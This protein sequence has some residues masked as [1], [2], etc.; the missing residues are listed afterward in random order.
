MRLI[1]AQVRKYRSIRDT[2][3][4]EIDLKKTILVGPNESG[5]TVLLQALQQLNPTAG[6]PGFEPL[7]DY[8]RSE[9]NDITTGAVKPEHVE[10]VTGWFRLETEDK[11]VVPVEYQ[12]SVYVF[13]RKL[14]NSYSHRL[15]GGPAPPTYKD[16]SGNLL[17]LA[18]HVDGRVEAP[19][20]GQSTPEKPSARLTAVTKEWADTQ[21]ITAQH[22]E[23]LREWLD[24]VVALVDEENSAETARLDKLRTQIQIQARRDAAVLALRERLPV[25][26]LFNNYFRVR[27]LIHLRHLARWR[28]EA[29]GKRE[30]A[31]SS[32]W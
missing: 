29:C 2:D 16:I 8:P 25:F 1:K 9:Y 6:I 30:V 27:P 22:G 19:A 18:A 23:A 13:S 12:D 26:V 21:A 4:F 24:G 11:A 32:G 3:V 5:K 28:P 20:A 10:V 17:R 14:D 15:E 31:H 7:R